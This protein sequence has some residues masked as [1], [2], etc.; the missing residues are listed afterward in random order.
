MTN[1]QIL[2]EALAEVVAIYYGSA[3]PFDLKRA[4]SEARVALAATDEEA[5]PLLWAQAIQSTH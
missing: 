2:R 3:C 5:I 1:E 4:M